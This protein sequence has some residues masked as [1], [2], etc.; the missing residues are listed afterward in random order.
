MPFHPVISRPNPKALLRGG[1]AISLGDVVSG[2]IGPDRFA[3]ARVVIL[4]ETYEHLD[5]DKQFL[6]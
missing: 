4:G 5:I 1:S 2:L 6:S 3:K